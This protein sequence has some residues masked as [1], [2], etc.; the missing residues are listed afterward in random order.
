VAV[1]QNG[2]E[3]VEQCRVVQPDLVI[4]D[5]KMPE[6]DGIDAAM[7]IYRERPV[8][9]ILVSAFSDAKLI[10][11]ALAEDI[12]A[13]L[14]KPIKQADLEPAIALALRRFEQLQ[15]LRE[16]SLTDELTGLYNRRGFATL[17]EQ[18]TKMARRLQKNLWL[19]F[20]DVDGLKQINDT[21]GHREGDRALRDTGEVLRRT[22]RASDILA[23]LGGDEFCILAVDESGSGLTAVTERLQENLKQ[24]NAQHPDRPYTLSFSIGMVRFDPASSPSIEEPLARADQLL[25]EQKRSKRIP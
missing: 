12:L 7:Q 11:R 8:P 10:E 14:I 1:A 6:L 24:H 25:Y 4:S 17:A 5:I 23:R 16:M 15:A 19:I 2:R 3:L 20:I 18:Q 9:I 13:Y 22:F 21:F